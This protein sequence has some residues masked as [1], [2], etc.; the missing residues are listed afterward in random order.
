MPG[1]MGRMMMIASGHGKGQFDISSIDGTYQSVDEDGFTVTGSLN[2]QSGGGCVWTGDIFGSNETDDWWLPNGTVSGTWHVRLTFDSGTDVH[3]GGAALNTWLAVGQ[4]WN[5]S[6]A[7]NGGPDP[8]TL[9]GNYTLS[10]SD[11]AGSTTHDSVAI[12]ISMQEQSA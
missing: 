11:D 5:F 10:W 12:A 2:V 4:T 9:T 6:K 7:H 8:E 1:M 3:S